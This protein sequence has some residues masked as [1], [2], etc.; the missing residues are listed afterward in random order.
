MTMGMGMPPEERAAW[1]KDAIWVY[2]E[3]RL[4][5]VVLRERFP[6]IYHGVLRD[7]NPTAWWNLDPDPLERG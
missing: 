2:V 7:N 1:I 4:R 5:L 6:E 3:A